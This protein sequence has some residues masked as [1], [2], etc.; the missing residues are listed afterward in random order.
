MGK[1]H[2]TFEDC[3]DTIS[4]TSATLNWKHY[5][6]GSCGKRWYRLCSDRT[7]A[8][9]PADEQSESVRKEFGMP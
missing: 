2:E 7:G 6:C 8:F 3:K 5:Q 1:Q 9:K 4:L